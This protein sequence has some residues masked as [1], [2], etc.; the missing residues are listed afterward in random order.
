[1]Q[2]P[3]LFALGFSFMENTKKKMKTQKSLTN[4]R[5]NVIY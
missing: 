2:K 1:M 3:L 5:A 4:K